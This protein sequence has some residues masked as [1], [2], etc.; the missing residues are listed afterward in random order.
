MHNLISLAHNHFVQQNRF[1][2]RIGAVLRV[3][4]RSVN[5]KLAPT[6]LRTTLTY[7]EEVEEVYIPGPNLPQAVC[8]FFPKNDRSY[9]V[10]MIQHKAHVGEEQRDLFPLSPRLHRRFV[11]CHRRFSFPGDRPACV[12]FPCDSILDLESGQMISSELEFKLTGTPGTFPN[13]SESIQPC[14]W[15]AHWDMKRCSISMISQTDLQLSAPKSATFT[16]RALK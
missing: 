1:P 16:T 6:E 12:N 13:S 2:R 8:D 7:L 3:I 15:R 5:N 11:P 10:R 4:V 9:E 14:R